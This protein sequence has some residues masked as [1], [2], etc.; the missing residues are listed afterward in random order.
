MI[1][2][3]ENINAAKNK[4][5]FPSELFIGGIFKVNNVMQI[6]WGTSTRKGDHDIQSVLPKQVVP[7]KDKPKDSQDEPPGQK[8]EESENGLPETIFQG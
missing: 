3:S 7:K 4:I 8:P 5:N 2:T 6:R 1:L